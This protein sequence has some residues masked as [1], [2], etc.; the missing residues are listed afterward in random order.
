MANWSLKYNKIDADIRQ[1]WD[2]YNDI[3]LIKTA[4]NIDIDEYTCSMKKF[5]FLKQKSIEKIKNKK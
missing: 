3:I 5:N 1:K 2:L 4:F